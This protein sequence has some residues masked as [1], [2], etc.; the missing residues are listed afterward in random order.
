[1]KENLAAAY[2]SKKIDKAEYDKQISNLQGLVDDLKSQIAKLEKEKG[3][4]IVQKDSLGKELTSTKGEN[5]KLKTENKIVS[6]KAG[7][8]AAMNITG[9]GVVYKGSKKK[10]KET[11]SAKKTE[12]VRICFDADKS[13]APDAGTKTFLVRIVSPQGVTL[14]VQSQGSGVFD[15]SETGEKMQ[16]TTKQDIDYKKSKQ[17][18][19][20]YWGSGNSG[21]FEKGKYTAEIYQDGYKIGTKEFTLK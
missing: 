6:T 15:M 17:N 20:I 18:V 5:D 19:C 12:K 10:E 1:M 2:K 4:L 9:T 3:V 8:L 7:L 11:T 13:P 14:A 16:Y 21:G